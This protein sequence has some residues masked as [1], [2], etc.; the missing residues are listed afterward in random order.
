MPVRKSPLQCFLAM[1]LAFAM[2]MTL[3]PNTAYGDELDAN[4]LEDPMPTITIAEEP[5][6]T[7]PANEEESMEGEDSQTQEENQGEDQGEDQGDGEV[8]E[9]VGSGAAITEEAVGDIDILD[10]DDSLET[11][12]QSNIHSEDGI[13]AAESNSSIGISYRSRA[14]NGSWSAVSTNGDETPSMGS[15][16]V[17]NAFRVKINRG[18]SSI[19]GGVQ[20]RMHVQNKG[21][22]SWVKDD[23]TGGSASNLRVEA[24]QVKLY[25]KMAKKYDVYTSVYV[26]G[27]GWL[28]WAKN[29][30]TTGSTG[31]S[32]GITAIKVVLVKKGGKAPSSSFVNIKKRFLNTASVRVEASVQNRGWMSSVGNGKVAG[33]TGNGLRLEALR[34]SLTGLEVPGEVLLKGNVQNVG[35]TS[36]RNGFVGTVG[37]SKRLE[38]VCIKLTGEAKKAYDIYYR[39]H[40]SRLGWMGWTKN[41]KKAGTSGFSAKIEAVQICLVKKGS[42]APSKKSSVKASFYSGTN[43][44]YNAYCQDYGWTGERRNGSVSGTTGEGKRLE[45]FT[46]KLSGGS[47]KGS[48]SYSAYVTGSGWQASRKNGD[49]AGTTQQARAVQAIK[50]SLTSH[51]KK[52]YDV[53]YKVHMAEVGWLGWAKNGQVAGAPGVGKAVQAIQVRLVPKGSKAPGSTSYHAVSKS[54]FDDEM[55]KKA[56]GYSSPT[57]WLIL[58]DTSKTVLGV[59]RGSFG[60]WQKAGSWRVSCGQPQTPTVKG[61]YSVGDRGYVFGHGYSCYWYVQWNGAYLFHSVKYYEGTFKIMDGRLGEHIS[62]GCVRMDI[63][64]AK[65]IY[66]NIPSGTTVVTY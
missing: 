44:C 5:T 25:G 40:V 4:T 38:A 23:A 14:Y 39:A 48:V 24:M 34:V 61:V 49:V 45:A 21:W 57:G 62:M 55:T 32:L 52:L 6:Q 27:E 58:V 2:A 17:V 30:E 64:R 12:T 43:V 20:Y 56:Q 66:D 19:T 65:W 7:T 26:R 16:A 63:E 13:V 28:A 50:I 10:Q 9:S 42:P 36:W 51:A 46:A 37:Q 3:V 60:N 22:L 18:E 1:F 15:S 35:W 59:Y 47:V 54:F 33:T 41:G 11:T 53:Y 8:Q 31:M 29:G